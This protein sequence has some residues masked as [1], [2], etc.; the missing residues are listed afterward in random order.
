MGGQVKFVVG[1]GGVAQRKG[2]AEPR[3]RQTAERLYAFAHAGLCKHGIVGGK[4]HRA[5][6][7]AL[8]HTVALAFQ[9]VVEDVRGGV[10][11]HVL[12]IFGVEQLGQR[13]ACGGKLYAQIGADADQ[14][15]AQPCGGGGV[16]VQNQRL[17]A[18]A[19]GKQVAAEILGRRAH[20]HGAQGTAVVERG[21]VQGTQGVGQGDLLHE[22]AHNFMRVVALGRPKL[23]LGHRFGRKTVGAQ[24]GHGQVVHGGGHDGA[25]G[26]A[27]Y[28]QN[29][30][31]VTAA[32]P[33]NRCHSIPPQNTYICII[34]QNTR[35]EKRAE[36]GVCISAGEIRTADTSEKSREKGGLSVQFAHCA[37]PFLGVE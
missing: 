31:A 11:V 4:I 32:R 22:L 12:K 21:A 9:L 23:T 6:R 20:L 15:L 17:Q 14:Q 16:G 30:C 36:R 13:F 3:Q 19:V 25:G 10:F 37:N 1:A 27:Q 28:A 24:L 18:A 34:A 5:R 8:A 7:E 26:I 29:F 35:R 2:Q 33:Q